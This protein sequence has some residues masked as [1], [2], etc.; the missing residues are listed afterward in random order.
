MSGPVDV[1]PGA[2][3][4]W[5]RG[6]DLAFSVVVG[7]EKQRV[8]LVGAQGRE[9]RVPDA[10]LAFEVEPPGVAPGRSREARHAAGERAA[11]AEARA[12]AL[13]A[14]VEVAVVWELTRGLGRPMTDAEIADLALGARTGV[15]RAGAIL[16][17][18]DDALH[19]VRRPEGW[20]PRGPEAVEEIRRQRETATRRAD[21]KARAQRALAAAA[22]GAPFSPTGTDAERRY[23]AALE[24]LAVFEEGAPEAQRE[25]A[26]EALEASGVACDRPHEGAFVLLRRAGRFASDDACLEIP[27]YGLRTAFPEA[28][29]CA[30]RAA[31]MRGFDRAGREDLTALRALTVDGPHT[32]EIDDALTCEDLGE[33]RLR[34][35]VHIADPTAFV[36]PG[37]EVDREALARGTTHYFPERRIPMIP[38]AISED[39][40]SLVAG[41][42]RPA[43]SFLAV[44]EDDGRVSAW[45][46]APSL[47]RV[48]ARLS[49]DDADAALRD[50]GSPHESVLRALLA[51]AD[52][53][54]AV[55][56]AAGALRLRAPEVEIHVGPDGALALERHDA[57]SP[58]HR[59]VSE[60]MVLAGDL[61][62]RF[63]VEREVPAIFRRQGPPD[64]RFEMPAGAVTDP[65]AARALRR[66]LRRGEAGLRPGPHY[67]L[68]LPAYA[69]V[70][71]P[72]RRFQD[73]AVHRQILGVLRGT[74]PAYDQATLQ[75][76]A[77]ATDAA[78]ADARRA[79]RSRDRYWM[80]RW[81]AERAGG[82]FEGTVVETAPRPVVLLDATVGEEV[83]PG[84]AAGVGER[85]RVRVVRANAR[86]G[87]LVLR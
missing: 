26:L 8:T 9:D 64:G 22:A 18:L 70:T 63:C 71:S 24:A 73:L 35:G 56:A 3:A 66:V 74:G 16:A 12:R 37:D 65:V 51:A 1:H 53:R 76:I 50:E 36:A 32:R 23:L 78:E 77:A 84:L 58:A 69:Q 27:R 49:Y 41:E 87:V 86:A 61:A 81:F 17:L 40:A 43:L 54:E 47:V 45:S 83:V 10:R 80:L 25:I 15:A 68:G 21:E 39:A 31:A 44:V 42:E 85:V 38:E 34:V 19:F 13:A 75:K 62:A 28:A 2:V 59:L 20:E 57:G 14:K 7:E 82:V 55:R 30:A 5:W 4:A 52:R 6:H 67:A 11:A 79:E 60:S 29:A 46:V 72:L 33:G 48:G